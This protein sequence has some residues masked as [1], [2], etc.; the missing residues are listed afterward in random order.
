MD[1]NE[2]DIR[3][4]IIV[5]AI[6]AVSVSLIFVSSIRALV[7]PKKIVK[8][9][10][11]AA[12]GLGPDLPVKFKGAE[13]GEVKKVHIV[14]KDDVDY[15]VVFDCSVDANLE[16]RKDT[17][18]VVKAI[19]FSACKK[20]TKASNILDNAKDIS[21][22]NKNVEAL[23]DI[24]LLFRT[25]NESEKYQSCIAIAKNIK[26]E[27]T[28]LPDPP[29][30]WQAYGESIAGPK[31]LHPEVQKAN[32]AS[33][34]NDIAEKYRWL[35]EQQRQALH[36]KE[37]ALRY[38]SYYRPVTTS[39]YTARVPALNVDILKHY[40]VTHGMYHLFH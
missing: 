37:M 6:F 18:A 4:G 19:G 1:Q 35:V 27:I 17:M 20:I 21:E 36:Q 7:R 25:L 29:A 28:N 24:A 5:V 2:K 26:N 31:R 33:A 15:K 9:G 23:M 40:F 14:S 39:P 32:R 12:G 22:E 3:F 8:V 38:S 13:V 30:G 10:F 34:D 16:I 11:S